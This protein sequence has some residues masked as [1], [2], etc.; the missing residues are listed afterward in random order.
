MSAQ[1]A[2]QPR[3]VQAEI[4]RLLASESNDRALRDRLDQ[5]A[6][7]PGFHGVPLPVWAP[8]LYRRDRVLFRP[9]ILSH[10]STSTF[11]GSS[12]KA[13]PWHAYAR[14]LDAWLQEVDRDDD[15]QLFR[16]LYRWRI[17]GAW[18]SVEKEWRRELLARMRAAA[19]RSERQGVLAR[20]DLPGALTEEIATELYSQDAPA[21]RGFILS[22]LPFGW[23]AL[24]VKRVLWRPLYELAHRL[25]DEDFAH[26]L[27][28]KQAP[29]DEWRTE[30]LR[31]CR[32]EADP[33]RL[34]SALEAV[35]PESNPW[36][37]K[38]L[39]PAFVEL[40]RARGR[41]VFPYVARHLAELRRLWFR[42]DGHRPLVE[43]A[44]EMGWWDLWAEVLR[45]GA[46]PDAFEKA[47]LVLVRDRTLPEAD[48]RR[49]LLL[50]AGVSRELHFGPF[51]LAA[52]HV[53]EDATAVALYER[54]PDLV[55]TAFRLHVGARYG[56][57]YPDLVDRV[58]TAGD[59]ALLD[60][61]ASR[62]FIVY[63]EKKQLRAADRMA[64]DFEA[65][66]ADPAAFARRAAAVL[67]HIPAYSVFDYARL[68]RENRL[69][70]LL[71]ERS[72]DAYLADP[73][74]LRDLLEAPE[75]HVQA[76]AFRALGR[77]DDRA[78]AAAAAN[79]DLLQAALFR[80]LHRR[81]RLLAFAALENAASRPE[82]ARRVV[83]R[84]REALALPDLRY[85]KEQL[86]GLLGRLLHRWP[87]LRQPHEQPVVHRAAVPA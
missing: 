73:A 49:R 59:G 66:A 51:S 65:L 29:V 74:A 36:N 28:R 53:L 67:G 42:D 20:F 70:R 40:L 26:A 60:Y 54:F 34:T 77:N 79:L 38:N 19:T 18:R 24:D 13:V 83:A 78:R 71:F 7:E 82:T 72:P 4:E 48:V 58:R 1:P 63:P 8:A 15:V 10:F 9:F 84:A 56:R 50:L 85:P 45:T 41:D 69:A 68:V 23:M 25:G 62:L 61:L 55:R 5:I 43:L 33:D 39:G 64:D 17:A 52:V 3:A 30:A 86:F 35:H 2:R 6:Q 27:F 81:T 14:D 22:H 11:F 75:I 37:P 12:F 76:L 47:V 31:L 16:R 57:A 44:R 46:R 32:D 80:P 87:D 21:A